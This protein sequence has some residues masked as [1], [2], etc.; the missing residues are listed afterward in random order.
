MEPDVVSS[1]CRR[2]ES[3]SF[4][5]ICCFTDEHILYP[6]AQ[7]AVH[8]ALV[9]DPN[10][11]RQLLMM[12]GIIQDST[13]PNVFYYICH[14]VQTLTLVMGPFSTKATH[15][16]IQKDYCQIHRIPTSMP[17]RKADRMQVVDAAAII[18]DL[19]HAH[20]IYESTPLATSENPAPAENSTLSEPPKPV[21]LIEPY[22]SLPRAPYELEKELLESLKND[23][24]ERFWNALQRMSEYQ[25]GTYAS[26]AAKHSEYGAVMMVSSMTRAIIDGG[27]P[28]EDAYELSDKILYELSLVRDSEEYD[29]ITQRAFT[30]FLT[31]S[32]RYHGGQ[33]ISPHIR[34]C[35][36]YIAH[37]LNQELTPDILATYLGLTRDYLLHLFT[38]AVGKPLMRYIQQQRIDA[39]KNM[40]KYTN[41]SVMTIAD[42][43]QFQN[44]SHF[45]RIFK[46]ATG[47]T[48]TEYRKAFKP[49]TV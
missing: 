42:Y 36:S 38:Q 4:Y 17:I 21:N 3:I 37:H 33:N 43:Y 46:Q 34:R 1:I 30:Q 48:P 35:Q 6:S 27:V 39:A 25:T 14:F 12:D 32:H 26:T 24:Q 40:L 20:G 44:Q 5:P 47:M 29:S 23:D 18:S 13:F 28:S 22:P 2:V 49:N 15:K 11:L 8:S 41:H 10:F 19:F 45:S 16:D 9:Y 31:L 7:R